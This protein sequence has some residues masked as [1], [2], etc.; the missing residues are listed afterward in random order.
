LFQSFKYPFPNIQ[1]HYTSTYEIQNIIQSLKT[2]NSY[3]FDEISVKILKLRLPFFVSPLTYICNKSLS[4]GVFPDRLK[5]SIVKP[6]YKNGDKLMMSNYRP[7]SLLTS[8][9]KVLEKLIYIRLYK[10]ISVN[11]ILVKEQ[12]GF[13]SNSSTEKASYK[14]IDEI[15]TAMNNKLFVGGQILRSAKGV[16]LC[17]S[18]N[19]A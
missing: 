4:L 10:H 19:I 6:I 11:N 15:L 16:R 3:G 7:I 2:K 14:L 18:Q 1:W 9:S 17:E 8:F 5:Y 13:R 12:Y